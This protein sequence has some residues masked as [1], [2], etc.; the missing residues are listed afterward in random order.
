MLRHRTSLVQK[1]GCVLKK[2]SKTHSSLHQSNFQLQNEAALMS[3][4][5]WAVER[6]CTAGLAGAYLG[7]QD[8]IFQ[9]N[10]TR[11]PTCL[12][13]KKPDSSFE[14]QTHKTCTTTH[15]IDIKTRQKQRYNTSPVFRSIYFP[16]NYTVVYLL[17]I[18]N[19]DH[20]WGNSKIFAII[21]AP[22]MVIDPRRKRLVMNMQLRLCFARAKPI[23]LKISQKKPDFSGFISKKSQIGN[24]ATQELRMRI[25]YTTKLSFFVM[26]RSPENL[27]FLFP[28]E[29]LWNA[30]MLVC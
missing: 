29:A 8:Q 22:C 27:V 20:F 10:T 23:W 21:C 18:N 26:Y 3:R 25:K 7:L 28:V 13:Q 24:P 5:I 11:L 2:G 12:Y 6:R 17:F 9:T 4:R 1:F 30:W 14:A 19:I 16:R 15:T